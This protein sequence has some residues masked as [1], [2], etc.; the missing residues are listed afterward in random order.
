MGKLKYLIIHC[1]DTPSFRKVTKENIQD[2]HMKPKPIGRGWDR[3]GYSDMIH[4]NG[5]VEN[6]T[7][8]N[9][10]NEVEAHEMTWGAKGVNAISRHVVYVG[11]QKKYGVDNLSDAQFLSL[12]RYVKEFLSQHPT[13]IIAGHNHFS[14][15]ACPNFNVDEF[16]NLIGI[17]IENILKY[18]SDK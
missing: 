15:K 1:T 9:E 13:A 12:Q 4:L 18:E 2:W 6:I 10:D 11:G 8:Y 5:D 3:P 16:C 7:P 17:P 14:T